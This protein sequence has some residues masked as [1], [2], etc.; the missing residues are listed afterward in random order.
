MR[1]ELSMQRLKLTTNENCKLQGMDLSSLKT[2][3]DETGAS[4]MACKKALEDA[5]GDIKKAKE[6]LRV[7]AQSIV[8]K[9]T[10]RE[11]DQGIIASYIHTTRKVGSLI[12][13]NCETDFVAR[14]QEFQNLAKELALHIAGMN[15]EDVKELLRQQYVRDPS[16]TIEDL[17]SK[18]I[19]SVGENIKIARFTRYEI[20]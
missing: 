3:R 11:A 19:S 8:E 6:S 12:E 17:I 16:L 1:D 18:T 5:K 7:T 13:L 2:L 14:T 15:P 9:K 20:K 4:I 10:D